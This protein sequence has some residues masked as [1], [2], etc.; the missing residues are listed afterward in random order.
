MYQRVDPPLASYMSMHAVPKNVWE[1]RLQLPYGYIP[2][3]DMALEDYIR[4]IQFV[5]R[6]FSSLL[7]ELWLDDWLDG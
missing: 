1:S 3:A 2:R 6:V 4:R 5:A 7:Q